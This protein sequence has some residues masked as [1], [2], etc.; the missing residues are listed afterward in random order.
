MELHRVVSD[1]IGPAMAWL[2]S[3]MDR[4]AARVI[5]LT[6]GL[7][8]T[9]F[10]YRRQLGD[11][12]ARS[13]WQFERGTKASRGGV[14]G[15]YLHDGSRDLLRA[16]CA[17]HGVTFEPRAIWEAIETDDVLAAICARLLMWT[18]SQPLPPLGNAAEAWKMYADRCWRPGKPHPETWPGYYAQALAEVTANDA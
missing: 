11:G 2:P 5:L 13:F 18:D 10:R 17:A 8:E 6:A 7:Q 4:P 3:K 1:M 12:P 16:A 9:Q 14:W 15:V